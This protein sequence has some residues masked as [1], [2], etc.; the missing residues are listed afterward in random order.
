MK[1][2]INLNAIDGLH[3]RPL[4]DELIGMIDKPMITN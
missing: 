3:R 1:K 4:Y 2:G